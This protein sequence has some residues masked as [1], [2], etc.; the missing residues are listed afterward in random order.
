MSN[1]V[2]DTTKP[3]IEEKSR[4]E[5][6]AMI[7]E[8]MAEIERLKQGRANSRNSSQPPSRDYKPNETK[9]RRRHKKVGAKDGHEKAERPLVDNPNR[10]IEGWAESCPKCHVDLLDQVPEHTIRRQ[11]TELPEIKPVVIETRQHEVRCPCCGRLQRGKLPEGLEA[12][13]Q[14]GPR[15]E[16]TVTNLHHEHHLGFERIGQ[17]C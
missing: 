1:M 7:Y 5:L 15:L 6:I 17:V 12:G 13:R 8:L 9:K 10:V 3:G 16:A 14:F 11:V 4:E 2:L